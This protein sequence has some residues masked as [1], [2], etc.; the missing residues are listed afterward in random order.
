VTRK[1]AYLAGNARERLLSRVEALRQAEKPRV[2]PNVGSPATGASSTDFS[3][4]PGYAELRM[5]RAVADMVG[6]ESPFFRVHEG[7][8]SATTQIAGQTCLNFSSYDYL[9][10]N[11]H[12]EV[13]AA[14]TAAIAQY[15]LSCSASRLV[16]GERP[17]HR[18]LERALADHYGVEDCAVFVS[19]YATNVGVIGQLVGPKDLLIYDAAIH[20]SAV[21]GG[22]LSG[23]NRRSFTHN[24]LGSLDR[25]LESIRDDFER[26]LIVVEGL[27]SM[28]GD[29]PQLPTLIDIK[30][31]HDAWL[32]VDEAHALGVL[33]RR[34]YGLAEHFGID[35]N[36]VDI[37]MG[38][39]SKTLAGCGGY[40]AGSTELVEY[41]KCMAGV[42]VYSVGLP[43]ALAAG[44]GKA[45]ELMHEE[46]ERVHQLQRNSRY[47][48]DLA[49]QHGLDTGAS[50]GTS[51][52]PI[53]VSDS[54]PA[55]VL[56]QRLLE[57]GINVLPIIY[58]AVPAK[59]S[60]LRF[61]ITATHTDEQIRTT[62]EATAEEL[63]EISS[64]ES[65]LRFPA[66]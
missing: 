20:N 24:D 10:L 66:S 6:I 35:G 39:L 17:I 55:V 31:R 28:D 26:V 25:L 30:R 41:L 36:A 44:A 46:P 49:Q 33:G 15:G 62:V 64:R 1:S 18:A 23:A 60:R 42:F 51:V 5:Q 16:A 21:V 61:F 11:G 40:I 43:P 38:T 56:S 58:P 45:L 7:R 53:M 4:L 14:A 3:T 19:G 59:A 47:F 63:R 22:L 57:R 9:G 54:L 52:C 37:W 65:L 32:M 48:H 29:Y 34:G 8:A 12:P 50:M 27:Y 13:A 2:L